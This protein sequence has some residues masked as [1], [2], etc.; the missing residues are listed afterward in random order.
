MTV[1]NPG[2]RRAD[3]LNEILVLLVLSRRLRQCRS[4]LD[5]PS[6]LHV[7]ERDTVA[8]WGATTSD[9]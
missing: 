4:R 9:E 7:R 6:G 1:D 3:R 8:L 5:H 2:A